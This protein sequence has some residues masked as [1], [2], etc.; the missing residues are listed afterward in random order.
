MLVLNVF[1]FC[2]AEQ[3]KLELTVAESIASVIIGY[4]GINVTALRNDSGVNV[5]VANRPTPD[6]RRN[7]KLEGDAKQLSLAISNMLDLLNVSFLCF[8]LCVISF[9]IHLQL[10]MFL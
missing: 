2:P 5:A 8:C 9:F 7:L 10:Q 1:F 3:I 4:E 6:G